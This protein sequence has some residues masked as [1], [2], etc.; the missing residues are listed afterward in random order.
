M[1]AATLAMAGP[2][3]S[4]QTPSTSVLEMK[5]VQTACQSR[6]LDDRFVIMVPPCYGANGLLR[7]IR[8]PG[9]ATWRQAE[10][11]NGFGCVVQTHDAP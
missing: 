7:L 9:D 4:I 11:D 8:A 5:S 1:I 10:A 2:S 3:H 6:S